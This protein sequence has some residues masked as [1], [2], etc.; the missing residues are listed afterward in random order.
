METHFADFVSKLGGLES[1]MEEK[2]VI[3]A[4]RGRRS[5]ILNGPF[6]MYMGMY[7]CILKSI[8][9]KIYLFILERVGWGRE[10]DEREFQA[11]STQAWG[12]IPGP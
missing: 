3:K 7:V 11:D 12:S 8:F 1:F 2:E 10:R 5:W 4:L 9:K 6:R